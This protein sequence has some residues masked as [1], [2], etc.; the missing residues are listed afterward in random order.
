MVSQ[1]IDEYGEPFETV[2]PECETKIEAA[3]K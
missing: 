1:L 2:L 3:Y